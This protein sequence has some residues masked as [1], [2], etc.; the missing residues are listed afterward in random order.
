MAL[1][2]KGSRRR[3]AA[4]P[5]PVA[6]ATDAPPAPAARKAAK[7]K[8]AGKVAAPPKAKADRIPAPPA[9][10]PLDRICDPANMGEVICLLFWKNRFR[11]PGMQT[12]I[13]PDD[14][15]R[16]RASCDWLE[17]R[18]QALI[19]RPPGAPARPGYGPSPGRPEGFPGSPA[20]GPRDFVVVAVVDEGTEDVIRTAERDEEHG[21]KAD[22]ARNLR[23]IVNKA[24]NL[25]AAIM[26]QASEGVYSNAVI[27][28][29]AE[30]LQTM[31]AALR[32]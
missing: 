17:V 21:V 6:A 27:T 14:I 1:V 32:E 31:A 22:R 15:D 12:T 30:A 25:A 29:A 3:P 11:N 26:G 9:V 2:E 13:T 7:K 23:N 20:E 4:P 24:G 18:P 5:A 10:N 8:R 28:E 16:F 19:K